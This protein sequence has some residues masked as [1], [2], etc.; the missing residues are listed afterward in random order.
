MR[1]VALACILALPTGSARAASLR[2]VAHS[3]DGKL[4]SGSDLLEYIAPHSRKGK[5]SAQ[6][7]GLLLTDI[8]GNPVDG[9]PWWVPGSSQPAVAWTNASRVRLSLPWP[10]REDGFSTVFLDKEGAGYSDGDTVD[11]NADAA[12]TQYRLFSESMQDR[13]SSWDPPYKPSPKAAKQQRK[14]LEAL[15]KAHAAQGPRERAMLYEKALTE[16]SLSWGRMLYEHGALMAKHPKIGPSLRWGL[17][18]D[19]SLPSRLGDYDNILKRLGKSGANWVRLVFRLNPDDFTYSNQRSRLE[20]DK[21]ISDL[22]SKKIHVMG[23][24]LD[25]SLWPRGLTSDALAQRTRNLV[26]HFKDRVRSWEVASEPNGTC[27]GGCKT[28]LSDEAVLRDFTAAAAE[29]KKIDPSLETVA[30]LYWW[31]GTAG[32]DVH[33][34]FPWLKRAIP[35]GAFTQIDMVAMSVYPDDNPMGMAFDTAFRRLA[36]YFPTKRL[37][38]GAFGYA[39]GADVDGYWW[40][41]PSDAGA[42]RSDLINLYTGAACAIPRA[43]GGGFW[44][45]TLDQMFRSSRDADAL[46]RV[47]QRTLWDLG[48]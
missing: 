44:W 4:L 28:P 15:A 22:E 38:L 26:L 7:S 29:V 27:L 23:S 1:P 9:R 12:L 17:T 24:V 47:Y 32:D 37:M 30:T 19:E 3:A 39:E 21:I 13:A 31:E 42:A 6:K 45:T 20:Y 2:L 43:A 41:D 25:S 11:L 10:V 46:F 40:L 5:A 48:R 14:L 33:A 35:R 18:L 34:T 36:Q 8:D 16:L